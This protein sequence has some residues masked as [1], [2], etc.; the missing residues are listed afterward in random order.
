MPELGAR[1]Q[2]PGKCWRRVCRSILLAWNTEIPWIIEVP[3]GFSVANAGA[4]AK[5]WIF[6]QR[7]KVL[8][9]K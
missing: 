5:N 6:G 7:C 1:T 4:G 8:S 2:G 9:T 3:V